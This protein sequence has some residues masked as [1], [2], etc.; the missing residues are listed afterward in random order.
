MCYKILLVYKRFWFK[1]GHD[2]H[3]MSSSQW[4][5]YIHC[6]SK[7]VKHWNDREHGALGLSA[8]VPRT[9]GTA[10]LFVVGDGNG[11]GQVSVTQRDSLGQAC[12]PA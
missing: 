6:Q 5:Q 7:D 8:R 9:I 10:R 12:G 1:L 2:D 3:M 11:T 4:L